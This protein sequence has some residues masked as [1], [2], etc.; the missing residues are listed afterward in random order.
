MRK[1]LTLLTLSILVFSMVVPMSISAQ[2]QAEK[3][4]YLV[5]FNDK[6]NKGIL[7][8]FGVDNSDVLHTYNLLP[9]NLVKMTEQQA[10]ALQNNPHIK[11]VEP[12]FEAQAFAQTVPWGVP[13][14]QGTDAHA[15]GHTGSGVKVAILDTGIDRNHEDLNVRGGHSVFTDSA[16]RDPYYD[17]SGHGTHVAGTVAAL[18]NSVGVLGVA[19]N[20]ELYAVKVL[21]NSGS[22]SYAGIAEGIEWAVNNGM[23][24]IN[25]SLGGSMSSSILEEWCNIAYNSGV[26]VVAAAGN[27]GRTNG[28]GDTVGYPAKYDSV[29]AVAAV[30]SSNNRASFSSTGPAVEIAAPGVNILSTTPGNSYASYNGTSMASPHVAGVAALVLAA[31]PNLS[32]VELRNR[33]NDTAQNLG[34][35]NHFGN[36]LVRAVDAINGTSSGDNGG[37][38]DGGS[39]PTKPGNGKGNG[40]N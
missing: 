33:L 39:E 16:N 26:L 11:A 22:G 38:D 20:A 34:D 1:L 18:N 35:A 21:N 19:Y 14:V 12:N 36:G 4:E 17:G 40:R 25:M 29:I 2:S 7:N 28:R 10:K 9:V 6:V 27:S 23:D 37:G 30:D 5:Q 13:H 32:N 8:A 15:A 31:N 24:I 3:Q